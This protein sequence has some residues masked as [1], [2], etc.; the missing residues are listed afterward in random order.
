VIEFCEPVLPRFAGWALRAELFEK[1]ASVTL[2]SATLTTAGTFDFVRREL[3]VPEGALEVV[4][5]TPFD[6]ERQALLV[7]PAITFSPNGE[8]MTATQAI[9]LVIPT[10]P[11]P[12]GHT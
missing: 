6:F 1:T 4:A 3:G 9:R 2:V 11:P 5:E 12:S 7:R 10:P 8:S